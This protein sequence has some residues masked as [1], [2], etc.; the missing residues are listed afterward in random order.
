MYNNRQ[1]IQGSRQAHVLCMSLQSLTPSLGLL[2]Q[3]PTADIA[4]A[5]NAG[6]EC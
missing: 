2:A 6:P 1:G 3:E 4:V 5:N